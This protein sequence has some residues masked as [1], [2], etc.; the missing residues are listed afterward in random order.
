[1]RSLSEHEQ[2]ILE[3]GQQAR[4]LL[5]EKTIIDALNDL[6]TDLGNAMLSTKINERQEREDLFLLHTSLHHLVAHLT[7]L[8]A[9]ADQIEK[10]LQDD[11]ETSEIE[12]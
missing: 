4:L 10:E 5:N 8:A 3:R 12:D 2:K 1:M 7:D 11:E 6:S 9:K